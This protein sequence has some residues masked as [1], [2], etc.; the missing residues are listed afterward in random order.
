MGVWHT[1]RAA[2]PQVVERRGQLIL[3]ASPRPSPA[4]C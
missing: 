2:L 1:V 4:A 3:V